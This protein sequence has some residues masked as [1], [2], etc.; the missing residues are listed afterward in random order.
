MTTKDQIIANVYK[1]YLGSSA[2]TLDRISSDDKKKSEADPSYVK[3]G[4]TKQ[5]VD[6]WFLSNDQLAPATKA[7]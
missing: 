1:K 3:S 6:K 4:I 2:Q 7:P 5:D